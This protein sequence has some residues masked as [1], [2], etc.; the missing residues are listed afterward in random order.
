MTTVRWGQTSTGNCVRL[1]SYMVI[2]QFKNHFFRTIP[3]DRLANLGSSS[4]C[5]L[6]TPQYHLRD[7]HKLP[8]C[9]RQDHN[10]SI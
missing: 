4:G 1:L 6:P 8:Q 2:N 10:V 9:Y 7:N 5:P 3:F